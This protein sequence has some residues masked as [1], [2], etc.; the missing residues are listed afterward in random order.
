MRVSRRI[1]LAQSL[2]ML[3]S[4]RTLASMAHVVL[5]G[6]SIFDNGSYTGG[7]PDVVTQLR[8]RLP[9]G[10]QASLLAVDGAITRDIPPQ[11]ARLPPDAT[12][13]VLSIGGND[14]LHF[15]HILQAQ[16]R[17]TGEGLLLLAEA[18]G[19]FEANYRAALAACL[20]RQLPL[21]L[22]TVYNGNFSDRMYQRQVTTALTVFNDA[23]VRAGIEHGLDVLDLR[24]VCTRP[25][26]YANPIEPS[27]V[28]GARIADAIVAI[29]TASDASRQASVFGAR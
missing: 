7:Q 3:A 10:W 24:L 20:A 2:I 13:L 21:V 12:H 19:T 16:V 29:I 9:A 15:Q 14:A 27:S 25:E 23:I 17:S 1:F 28:G 6:D 5:L 8:E 18:V 11:L 26:D 4:P 22:C